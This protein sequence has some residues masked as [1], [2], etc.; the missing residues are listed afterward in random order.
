LPFSEGSGTL[1]EAF[2]VGK[3]IRVRVISVDAES[4]RIVGSILKASPNYQA[5]VAPDISSIEVGS[6]VNGTVSELHKE[7]VL[8]SLKPSGVR[9]ILS[10]KNL[11]NHRKIPVAQLRGSLKIG[12]EL[13]DLFVVTREPEKGF[14]I[15]ASK[16]TTKAPLNQKQ[17]LSMDTI[18]VG[19]LVGG[20]VVRQ[21]RNGTLLKLSSSITGSLHP[22]D[23]SDDYEAG[24]IFPA[25]DTILRAAVLSIDQ[26][27]N[28]LK[29]SSRASRMHPEEHGTVVDP[30]INNLGDLKIGQYVRGFVKSVAE[31]GLFIT[32]SSDIDARVQIKE[33]FDEVGFVKSQ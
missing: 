6:N 28:H 18:Q 15:V 25:V 16:P 8:L 4:Q 2:S 21:H 11:A 26:E 31:H 27:K 7:N 22:T 32:L 33:L 20:R 10:F 17:P 23:A 29:L 14:V 19:Q 9:A 30:E 12:D 24:V 13:D 5:A 3:P 1:S